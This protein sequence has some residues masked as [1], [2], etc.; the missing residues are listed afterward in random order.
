MQAAQTFLSMTVYE[1]IQ[2]HKE[3]KKEIR[4][5]SGH[6]ADKV[7]QDVFRDVSHQLSTQHNAHNGQQQTMR[8]LSQQL[9]SMF[10]TPPL[11]HED[12]QVEKNQT[13]VATSSGSASKSAAT[14]TNSIPKVL[15][16]PDFTRVRS[17][18]CWESSSEPLPNFRDNEVSG[19]ETH[20][21]Q[22]DL[23]TV[24][25]LEGPERIRRVSRR[26][27]IIKSLTSTRPAP[28][29]SELPAD[30]PVEQSIES[31][32]AA[33]PALSTVRQNLRSKAEQA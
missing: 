18:V 3:V 19:Q 14:T 2:H 25:M 33:T 23:T 16:G 21:P 9:S 12:L 8:N 30:L 13:V 22:P 10:E 7:Q 4:K 20:P 26:A 32:A 6:N 1:M 28:T 15:V 5:R 31:S 11:Q 17:L 27:Q 29:S 24:Q